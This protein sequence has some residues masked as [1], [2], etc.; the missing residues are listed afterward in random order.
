MTHAPAARVLLRRLL[1][2][3]GCLIAAGCAGPEPQRRTLG[4]LDGTAAPARRS[5]GGGSFDVSRFGTRNKGQPWTI[6]LIELEG[7][8]AQRHV[9]TWA[10]QLAAMRNI[11]GK[12]VSFEGGAD[13]RWRLYYGVYY[14][15]TD[16]RGVLT[17]PDQL[18]RDFDMLRA[19]RADD[20]S[21][22]FAYAL[23]VPRPQPC[24][25]VPAWILSEVPARYSL[26]VAVF[27]PTDDFQDYR[28]AAVE[29]CRFL[30]DEGFEAYY[31]H[32]SASSMVTVGSFDESALKLEIK[33]FARTRDSGIGREVRSENSLEVEALR[34]NEL[35]RYNLVNGQIH[36][37]R[38]LDAQGRPI[39]GIEAQPV[40][41]QLVIIPRPENAE[42][43]LDPS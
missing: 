17:V 9:A 39:A 4:E 32:A 33:T 6:Q 41:S 5:T 19:L 26:Q 31:H 27:L 2:F 36:R 28:Q 14:R 7:P 12:E 40:P 21:A 13:G 20:G 22:P 3:L 10:D 25:E 11:R 37:V 43:D 18:R 42:I 38:P 35:L 8:F 24:E 16:E 1:A 30:R 15:K 34:Q 29:Y 23:K